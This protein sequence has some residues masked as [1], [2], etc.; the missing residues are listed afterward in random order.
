M[1][2]VKIYLSS[3]NKDKHFY[4]ELIVSLAGLKREG[5]IK[6][7][8]ENGILPGAV[9]EE[10]IRKWLKEAELVLFLVSPDLIASDF[11]YDVEILKALEF[12]QKGKVKIIPI[13]IRP[14]DFESF[15]ICKFET[16]PLNNIPVSVWE[17]KDEAWLEITMRLKGIVKTIIDEKTMPIPNQKAKGTIIR[18]LSPFVALAAAGSLILFFTFSI[19]DNSYN[20]FS[21]QFY[22]PVTYS[23]IFS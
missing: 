23:E 19:N 21:E 17:N 15:P 5:K 9:L 3:S 12:N 16:L 11:I 1:T 2:P 18:R 10:Q 20:K 13:I 22:S 8:N 6:V 14:C 4:Q 7:L